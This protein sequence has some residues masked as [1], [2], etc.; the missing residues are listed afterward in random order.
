EGHSR[1]AELSAAVR[2][3]RI[4]E[5]LALDQDALSLQ[6][7]QRC[8]GRLGVTTWHAS[9]RPLL[10]EDH[11]FGPFNL[12]YAAGLYDYLT[13]TTARRLTRNLFALLAPGGWL[14]VATFLPDVPAVGYMESY[15]AWHLLCRTG[16]ELAALADEVP[17]QAIASTEVFE[18][19]NGNIVLLLLTKA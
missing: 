6:E 16:P 17:P 19:P 7:I 1:E 8:Y 13:A 3:G 12:I 9:L 11:D 10:T 4:G 18:D 5:Y 15:M 14:L 2:E